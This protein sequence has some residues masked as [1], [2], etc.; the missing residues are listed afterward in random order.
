MGGVFWDFLA[1]LRFTTAGP[2]FTL[3][4]PVAELAAWDVGKMA[5]KAGSSCNCRRFSAL[6]IGER[7]I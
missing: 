5:S 1:A 7:M 2:F 6:G 3:K 4:S